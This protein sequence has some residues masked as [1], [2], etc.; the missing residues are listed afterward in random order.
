M[1]EEEYEKNTFSASEI[2]D[3]LIFTNK[4]HRALKIDKSLK[5]IIEKNI[6]TI[7]SDYY[8]YNHTTYK[9]C[10]TPTD[11]LNIVDSALT[12]RINDR[13]NKVSSLEFQNVDNYTGIRTEIVYLKNRDRNKYTVSETIIIYHIN[14][15][16][17]DDLLAEFTKRYTNISLSVTDDEDDILDIISSEESS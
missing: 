13:R 5:Y 11:Y 8:E 3:Q 17:Y 1:S 2:I 14:K 16:E 7:D 12:T 4:L 10:D 9:F 6:H 15:T